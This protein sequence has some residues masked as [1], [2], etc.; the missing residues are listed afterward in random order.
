MAENSPKKNAKKPRQPSW[1]QMDSVWKIV[2]AA[3]LGAVV[4]TIIITTPI[5]GRFNLR[6]VLIAIACSLPISYLTGKAG[7]RY[8]SIIELQ[9]KKLE[10]LNRDIAETNIMLQARNTELDAFAHTVAHDLNNQLTGIINSGQLLLAYYKELEPKIV[11]EQLGVIVRNGFNAFEIVDSMLLLT[12]AEEEPVEFKPLDMTE[13]VEA[14]LERQ[15]T[16]IQE[17]EARIK[18][19][20]VWPTVKG[21][22]PW[23]KSIWSNYISNGIKYGG[24]PPYLVL[25]VD[26]PRNQMARFWVLDNGPGIPRE[27]LNGLFTRYSQK[28]TERRP[29]HGLGLSIV[30]RIVERSGGKVGVKSAVGEGSMFYFELPL[31]EEIEPV[32]QADPVG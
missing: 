27:Q 9:K 29:G 4:L 7:L 19:A 6:S 24:K 20:D 28:G 13:L 17:R 1:L 32:N 21:Y 5:Y 16:L 23:V 31:A 3:V 14:A 11:H 10:A 15:R 26:S 18:V 25:G 12:S 8:K 22:G 2:T 30:R